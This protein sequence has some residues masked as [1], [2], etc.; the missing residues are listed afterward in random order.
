MEEEKYE[1]YHFQYY[2][3]KCGLKNK[4]QMIS[5][6]IIFIVYGTSEFIAI[7]LPLL[8]INPYV[9]YFDTDLNKNFTIQANYQNCNSTLKKF[10]YEIVKEKSK[11]SLVRDFNIFCDENKVSFI[12][13][14][15][16]FGVMLGSFI[17]YFFSDKIGRKKTIILFS[18]LYSVLQF[19]YLINENLYVMYAMLSLSGLFYS[20]II[21]SSI[22]LLNEVIDVSLT[23]IF[24]TIIYNAYPLFG[25]LYDVLFIELDDWRLIFFIVGLI[26]FGITI[27][28]VLFLEESP[29]FYF[30]NRDFNSLKKTLSKIAAVNQTNIFDVVEINNI[31]NDNNRQKKS[32]IESENAQDRKTF[33]SKICEVNVNMNVDEE[34]G[35]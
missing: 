34:A 30:C 9:N 23:A 15:L 26:H 10:K 19:M 25:I 27:I 14:S 6:L 29:R 5:L 35:S 20:I 24:T 7:A 16:F 22:L 2:L 12:G 11:S 31:F 13:S 28:V 21:L 18:V 33:I 1:N 32:L 8:E 4:Y 17:S 3:E